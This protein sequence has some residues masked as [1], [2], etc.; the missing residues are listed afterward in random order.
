MLRGLRHKEIDYA[1]EFEFLQSFAR[2]V[3]IGQ[4]NQRIEAHAKQCLYLSPMNRL[5]NL[6]GAVAGL[7]QI[8][9]RDAP[10][11][12]NM[13]A[14]G[15]VGKHALAGKLVAFLPMLASTLPIALSRDHGAARAFAP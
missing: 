2:V 14:R 9:R 3:G 11:V 8:V 1:K 13:L 6:L 15:W 5:H 10:D 4:R 7:R 12:R